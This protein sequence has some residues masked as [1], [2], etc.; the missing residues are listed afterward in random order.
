MTDRLSLGLKR[1]RDVDVVLWR[2]LVQ[3][4]RSTGSAPHTIQS[5][6][7][8]PDFPEDLLGEVKG[9]SRRSRV[10]FSA[11][12]APLP[13]VLPIPMGFQAGSLRL[14]AKEGGQAAVAAD[15]I[16]CPDMRTDIGKAVMRQLR[17]DTTNFIQDV[18]IEAANCWSY[19]LDTPRRDSCQL[20]HAPPSQVPVVGDGDWDAEF[21]VSQNGEEGLDVPLTSSSSFNKYLSVL[22]PNL[23]VPS[24]S[25]HAGGGV[26]SAVAMHRIGRLELTRSDLDAALMQVGFPT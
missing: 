16:T 15:G 23:P 1:S 3:R 9:A 8:E 24:P 10:L 19:R 7:G 18:L 2:G 12:P 4:V 21:S 17:Q 26:A 20:I 25:H 13:H 22:L 11:P 5:D 14:P 6:S